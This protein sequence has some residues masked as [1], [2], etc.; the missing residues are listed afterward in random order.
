MFSVPI[1]SIAFVLAFIS[2]PVGFPY[3]GTPDHGQPRR[4]KDF[5]NKAVIN[6]V[7][8]PGTLL[9]LLATLGLTAGFEEAGSLFPWRSAYVI[10]LLTVS[11]VLFVALAVWERHVTV[12]AT[13]REP[14]LPTRLFVSR[15][16]ISILL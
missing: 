10:S 14:V 11:G 16:M 6:R 1:A 4:A 5:L 12:A 2:I 3:H 9:I 13:V 15:Q 7:D 8:L